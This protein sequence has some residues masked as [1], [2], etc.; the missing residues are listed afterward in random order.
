MWLNNNI[1]IYIYVT[2]SISITKEDWKMLL[3]YWQVV[4]LQSAS[5][6]QRFQDLEWNWSYQIEFPKAEGLAINWLSTIYV[7]R[8]TH[9]N[10]VLSSLNGVEMIYLGSWLVTALT[11][12]K[13]TQNQKWD[14]NQCHFLCGMTWR[15]KCVCVIICWK[16]YKNLQ[17]CISIL[18]HFSMQIQL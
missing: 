2:V 14:G 18:Y 7:M 1:Y 12:Q 16:H 10:L 15:K 5:G 4:V 3:I 11:R 17:I 6:V 13:S 9:C 8:S